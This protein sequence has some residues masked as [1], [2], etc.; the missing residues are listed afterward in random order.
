MAPGRASAKL[1]SALSAAWPIQSMSTGSLTLDQLEAELSA[2]RQRVIN[3]EDELARRERATRA[4]E[5]QGRKYPLSKKQYIRYGRQMIL[6]SVGIKGRCA[7]ASR[8]TT[9][10]T[11][12]STLRG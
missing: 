12:R 9:R 3:L 10:V 1:K 8:D 11:R 4:S 7:G 5:T 6:P 2:A